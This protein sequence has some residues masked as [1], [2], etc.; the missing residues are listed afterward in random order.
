MSELNT[1]TICKEKKVKS[2]RGE[3]DNTICRSC[4]ETFKLRIKEVDQGKVISLKEAKKL[5]FD[6]NE[7]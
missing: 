2:I 6:K 5:I 4:Q 3:I 1:C 7:S